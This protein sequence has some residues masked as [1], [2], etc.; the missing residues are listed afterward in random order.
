MQSIRRIVEWKRASKYAIYYVCVWFLTIFQLKPQYMLDIFG[1]MLF[2][3]CIWI[4]HNE[5]YPAF[6]GSQ[7][8]EEYRAPYR[9]KYCKHQDTLLFIRVIHRHHFLNRFVYQ[10]TGILNTF[11]IG[12]VT[13][14]WLCFITCFCICIFFPIWIYFLYWIVTFDFSVF[15]YIN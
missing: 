4:Y 15:I 8:M 9:E 1:E 2:N 13:L 7:K 14:V 3:D 10:P 5:K 12:I 11:S 6:F